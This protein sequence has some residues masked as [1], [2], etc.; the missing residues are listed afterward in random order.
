MDKPIESAEVKYTVGS[1]DFSGSGLSVN[2]NWN[3]Q[4]NKDCYELTGSSLRIY[5][6]ARLSNGFWGMRNV[7]NQK[8]VNTD[9]VDVSTRLC[10]SGMAD[11]QEAGITHFNGGTEYITLGIMMRNG[12]K[13]IRLDVNGNVTEGINGYKGSDIYFRTVV[14]ETKT[15]HMYYSADNRSWTEAGSAALPTADRYYYKGD[16]IGLYTYNDQS[17]DGYV[18]FDYFDYNFTGPA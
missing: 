8:Y 15:A 11:G 3:H 6:Q 13:Y 17:A 7:I 18:D 4:T 5:A 16:R 2:W 10:L 12:H 9:Y 14:D 1:D